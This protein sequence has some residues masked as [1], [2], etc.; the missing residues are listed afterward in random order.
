MTYGFQ[1][2]IVTNLQHLGFTE[3][4]TEE[5]LRDSALIGFL[6]TIPAALL[7]GF[8]SSKKTI[9]GLGV[10]TAAA[11]FCFAAAGNSITQ[12]PGLLSALLIIPVWSIGSMTAILAAY[13]AEVYPTRVR[14]RGAGLCA[15]VSK[16]GGVLVIGLAAAAV[17][18]PS[19][20][21]TAL[22]SG[23]PIALAVLAITLVGP[24]TQQRSLEEIIH[25][26][27]T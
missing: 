7:Y 10:L 20:T 22:L 21:I 5:T 27:G 2:W 26:G 14:S 6:L 17:T 12:H 3:R 19:I 4:T 15:G 9:I 23:V 1:L 8:W 18:T 13:S 25:R 24:E 11:L 16:A